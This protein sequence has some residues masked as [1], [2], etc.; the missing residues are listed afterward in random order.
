MD[1]HE[2][3]IDFFEGFALLAGAMW[4]L[5]ALLVGALVMMGN[6]R[7]GA[8]PPPAANQTSIG[9]STQTQ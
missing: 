9:E 7:D 2:A 3:G 4:I 6:S 1:N 8:A 5:G